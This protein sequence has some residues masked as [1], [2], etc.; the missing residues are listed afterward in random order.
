MAGNVHELKESFYIL[1][2]EATK[3]K[4]MR[5][6]WWVVAESNYLVP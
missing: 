4:I 2:N 1:E 5:N 3:A 6:M